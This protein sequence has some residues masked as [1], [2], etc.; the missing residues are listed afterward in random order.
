MDRYLMD[1]DDFM[2]E[3]VLITS[4]SSAVMVG[5]LVDYSDDYIELDVEGEVVEI[6]IEPI[7]NIRIIE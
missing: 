7:R 3:K 2:G 4:F 6:P 1:F 5:T